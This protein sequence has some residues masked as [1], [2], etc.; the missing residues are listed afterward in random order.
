[1]S[2]KFQNFPLFLGF[3][4]KHQHENEGIGERYSVRATNGFVSQGKVRN[5]ELSHGHIRTGLTIIWVIRF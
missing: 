2:E 4:P 5:L 1:M 3:Y